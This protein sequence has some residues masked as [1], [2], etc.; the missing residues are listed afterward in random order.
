MIFNGTQN[1]NLMQQPLLRILCSKP[2]S[3][4]VLKLICFDCRSTKSHCPQGK[5]SFPKLLQRKPRALLTVRTESRFAHC[6]QGSR[7]S[8]KFSPNLLAHC[9]PRGAKLHQILRGRLPI[10]EHDRI[11]MNGAASGLGE[12]GLC[13]GTWWVVH[14]LGEI[15]KNDG[16]KEGFHFL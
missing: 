2:G 8:P 15:G 6:P 5:H 3:D 14:G 16:K 9:P 11:E 12:I 1:R 7:V 10:G 13:T 4:D